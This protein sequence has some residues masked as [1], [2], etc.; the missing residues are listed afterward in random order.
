MIRYGKTI[1]FSQEG[2]SRQLSQQ[3]K[4]GCSSLLLLE[5]ELAQ[6]VSPV[7]EPRKRYQRKK[8]AFSCGCCWVQLAEG[9]SET[10]GQSLHHSCMLRDLSVR[11]FFSFEI[12]FLIEGGTLLP[13]MSAVAAI[14]R[15]E[16][17]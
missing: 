11:S 2:V 17:G 7:S 10:A 1:S 16:P 12:S 14:V 4:L 5:S 3:F 6:V 15:T 9:M 8:R 13:N